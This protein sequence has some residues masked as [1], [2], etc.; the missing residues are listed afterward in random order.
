MV[1]GQAI[2]LLLRA[3]QEINDTKYREASAKALN[4]MLQPV[5]Q[6]GTARYQGDA[7]FL[8]EV[9]KK[10]LNPILNGWI[11][12]IFG[13]WDYV[14]LLSESQAQESLVKTLRTLSTYLNRYDRGYWSNYD[15]QGS[16]ASPFYHTLHI[17]LLDALYELSGEK[18]FHKT[19]SRWKMYKKSLL[20][21]GRAAL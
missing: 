18:I 12:A 8:E 11:F 2:S 3:Y 7:L 14:L 20:N 9:V 15:W 17:A 6:G 1:Q 19:A 10:N 13:I 21:R 16:I 4:L 5:G